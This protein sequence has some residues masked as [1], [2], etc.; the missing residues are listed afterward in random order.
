M[1]TIEGTAFQDFLQGTPA[2]DFIFGLGSSQTSFWEMKA[3][4]FCS[5]AKV[6]ISSLA[7]KGRTRSSGTGWQ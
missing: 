1:A 4:T 5:A 7:E 6:A 2:Q 3:T